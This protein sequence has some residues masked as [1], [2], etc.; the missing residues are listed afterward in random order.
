M[1]SPASATPVLEATFSYGRPAPPRYSSRRSVRS[2]GSMSLRASGAG[3]HMYFGLTEAGKMLEEI[4]TAFV[5]LLQGVTPLESFLST[6]MGVFL[7]FEIERRWQSYRARAVAKNAL[8][9]LR[10]ELEESRLKLE[11]KEGNLLPTVYWRSLIS[12]GDITLIESPIRGNIARLF[13]KIE[14]HNYEAEKVRDIADKAK[15]S[16]DNQLL[17]LWELYS[18]R[19]AKNEEELMHQIVELLAKHWWPAS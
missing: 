17:S 18:K 12:T 4:G 19:L 16:N 9:N 2:S 5:N 7:A 3:M 13:S 14:I 10:E 6:L 8:L 11:P 1:I 15:T